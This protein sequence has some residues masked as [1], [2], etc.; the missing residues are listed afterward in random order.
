M[1]GKRRKIDDAPK[2]EGSSSKIEGS[3]F[4]VGVT[5]IKLAL[6]IIVDHLDAENYNFFPKG[7]IDIP[8]F[9]ED[10]LGIE[11]ESLDDE[12]N[13][14]FRYNIARALFHFHMFIGSNSVVKQKHTDSS[15]H[16]LKVSS[17]EDIFIEIKCLLREIVSIHPKIPKDMTKQKFSD[18]VINC[19][20]CSIAF[21]MPLTFILDRSI[22]TDAENVSQVSQEG[23][24]LVKSSQADSPV[25]TKLVETRA[26]FKEYRMLNAEST[27]DTKLKEKLNS[28]NLFE[29][30]IKRLQL[31]KFD[32]NET[33]GNERHVSILLVLA[34]LNPVCEASEYT[35]RLLPE[36]T[37]SNSICDYI[38]KIEKDGNLRVP[39]EIKFKTILEVYKNK[40]SKEFQQLMNQCLYQMY[41]SHCNIGFIL[42]GEAMLVIR[43][44]A[45]KVNIRTDSSFSVGVADIHC[46]VN[47]YKYVDH[48][49]AA[50]LYV[51]LHDYL[52]K[53]RKGDPAKIKQIYDSLKITPEDDEN[54]TNAKYEFVKQQ[55]DNKFRNS[56]QDGSSIANN[57]IMSKIPALLRDE[58]TYLEDQRLNQND[59]STIKVLQ[60][61]G[62]GKESLS[63]VFEL[64]YKANKRRMVLKIY[65]V[66]RAPLRN[67]Y[68]KVENFKSAYKLCTTM[69]LT[70]LKAY[71]SL[72]EVNGLGV[73][74]SPPPTREKDESN[75]SAVDHSFDASSQ[76][77][78]SAG[79]HSFDASSQ[80]T[81]SAGGHS[82]DASSQPT[83]SA[84]GHSFD[85]SSQ[86][87]QSAG[88]HS[89]D[90]SSQPTQSAVDHSFDASSQ[91]TQSAGGHSFDASS[92][93][94]QS[95]GGHSFDASSQPTQ[96]PLVHYTPYLY[97]SG[98]TEWIY[99]DKSYK[100][101]Y[102]LLE[103]IQ[104]SGEHIPEEEFQRLA[105]EA[106]M[107]IHRK[108]FLHGD[109]HIGNFQ[110]DPK[111]GR[112][113]FY[114]FGLSKFKSQVR[115]TRKLLNPTEQD[116][117]EELRKLREVIHE[118]Y[119]ELGTGM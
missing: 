8:K 67:G 59:F 113:I 110:Y 32:A 103:L 3:S 79:G 38:L 42:D 107:S 74:I 77:T 95:A 115:D 70:E 33:L 105:K 83:Q 96:P 75:Q 15:S 4:K 94:T 88:G 108:G 47:C 116:K 48:N 10:T 86:P 27:I 22:S 6:D 98:Y 90:A 30:G 73:N 102:L 69:F 93:P 101:Y 13:E 117:E 11:V 66:M 55:W 20:D 97:Q 50:I 34:V 19:F 52:R 29:K 65:D 85:A 78:Q 91:P 26:H 72:R 119:I 18:F 1:T 2:I 46:F 14:D 82:F 39:I 64:V 17:K 87:T 51:Y 58:V 62:R 45:K 68:N 57:E 7:L 89:F 31:A 23:R 49:P 111:R 112:V 100:G 63:Q 25:S 54:E 43:L 37:A 53:V 80:P 44:K 41:S 106:L 36:N 109:I 21:T 40:Q 9:N 28:A 84:G 118:Y 71:R 5:R 24:E 12:P 61:S 56:N 81:Q 60:G 92:Q 99:D 76:P 114:D 35:I 104:Q 16:E